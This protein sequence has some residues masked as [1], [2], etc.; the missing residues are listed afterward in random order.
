MS[1]AG[2]SKAIALC[3]N[4][5]QAIDPSASCRQRRKGVVRR[6]KKG[7]ISVLL[8][9]NLLVGRLFGCYRQ[10]GGAVYRGF[11]KRGLAEK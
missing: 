7:F 1:R 8:K 6:S 9:A 11:K 10:S 5:W 2:L 4:L 3:G